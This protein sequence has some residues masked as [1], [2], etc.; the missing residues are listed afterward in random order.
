LSFDRVYRNSDRSKTGD[1]LSWN[2]SES[3]FLN[4]SQFYLFSFSVIQFLRVN[5]RPPNYDMI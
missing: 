1:E 4:S 3:I 2:V 5:L